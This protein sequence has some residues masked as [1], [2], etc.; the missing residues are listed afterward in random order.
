MRR[1]TGAV[2]AALLKLDGV[3][4]HDD[5]VLVEKD[6]IGMPHLR[7]K[8]RAGAIDVIRGGLPPL[9]YET[10]EERAMRADYGEVEF[11]VAGL[12]HHRRFQAP[13]RAV[14]GIATI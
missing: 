14:P 9:D 13:C 7:V 4:F 8:T 2:L 5:T 3:R 6:L 1:T 11:P 10:V 12:Q